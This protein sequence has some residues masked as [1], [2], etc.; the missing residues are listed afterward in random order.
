MGALGLHWGLA[1]PPLPAL[2]KLAYTSRHALDCVASPSQRPGG[3]QA[4]AILDAT[5]GVSLGRRP[6]ERDRCGIRKRHVRRDRV[7]DLQLWR[8]KQTCCGRHGMP[9]PQTCLP[10]STARTALVVPVRPCCKAT[11]MSGYPGHCRH[12]RPRAGVQMLASCTRRWPPSCCRP[13]CP[14]PARRPCP[15][16]LLL[17][18]APLAGSVEVMQI[19]ADMSAVLAPLPS[20]VRCGRQVASEGARVGQPVGLQE[21]ST[22]AL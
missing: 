1:C 16:L 5:A 11:S 14:P 9:P 17:Q 20:G 10:V 19:A 15:A 3:E 7:E 6:G 8:G 2:P 22:P 4:H 21:C 18:Q 12:P 13:P